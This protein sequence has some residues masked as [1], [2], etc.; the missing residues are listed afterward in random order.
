MINERKKAEK[1]VEVEVDIFGWL[2]K[3]MAYFEKLI[4][5]MMTENNGSQ[6]VIDA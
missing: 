4:Q 3:P 2:E 1:Y 6:F 5:E